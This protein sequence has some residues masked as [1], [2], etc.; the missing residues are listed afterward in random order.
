MTKPTKQ[1]PWK[2]AD[3]ALYEVRLAVARKAGYASVEAYCRAKNK[4]Q[5]SEADIDYLA[6]TGKVP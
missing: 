4:R 2:K 6:N 5:V 1:H 3:R